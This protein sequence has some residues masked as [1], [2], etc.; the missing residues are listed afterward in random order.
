MEG[1]VP[2]GGSDGWSHVCDTPEPL[3]Y[4]NTQTVENVRLLHPAEP[5]FPT[6]L[7]SNRLLSCPNSMWHALAPPQPLSPWLHPMDD[8]GQLSG[9][10]AHPGIAA[11]WED[12]QGTHL[13]GAESQRERDSL[14][15]SCCWTTYVVTLTTFQN[16]PQPFYT[17]TAF[18]W[19]FH[20]STYKSVTVTAVEKSSRLLWPVSYITRKINIPSV[21]SIYEATLPFS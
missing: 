12:S 4:T 14:A 8:Q 7:P 9:G 21:S 5:L 17:I 6:S 2:S 20:V 15:P 16:G 10:G 19:F 13:G 18:H 1:G 11:E 3:L